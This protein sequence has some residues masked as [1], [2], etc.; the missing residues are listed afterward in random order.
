MAR[1]APKLHHRPPHPLQTFRF[2]TGLTREACAD[3]ADLTASTVQN[4]ELGKA[5]LYL[6]NAEL[7]E[8]YTGC[9]A[10]KL[11]ELQEQWKNGKL[12]TRATLVTLNGQ[13]FTPETYEAYK[14]TPIPAEDRERAIEDIR[15]RIDLILGGL[16][17]RSHDFRAAYRRMS[18]FTIKERGRAALSN[19]EVEQRGQSKA[20]VET[21]QMTLAQLAKEEFLKGTD[22]YKKTLSK[23]YKPS[24]KVNVSLEEF[25]SWRW[26]EK[27]MDFMLLA[28]P[29]LQTD[30]TFLKRLSFPDKKQYIL[31]S[32]GVRWVNI[33][34]TSLSQELFKEIIKPDRTEDVD[35]KKWSE[36]RRKLSRKKRPK[37]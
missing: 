30:T 14:A 36:L 35:F 8:A 24:T 25:P 21:K 15:T 9:S 33:E 27:N 26:S 3:I 22:L 28:T 1:S 4:I 7:I 6:E 32:Q 5:P 10:L 29:N 2:V 20:I 34:P 12:K 23:R 16:G 11:L 37:T 19:A 13:P 18:Q 17:E 31:R